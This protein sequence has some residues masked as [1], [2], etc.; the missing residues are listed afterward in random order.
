MDQP[1]APQSGAVANCG[2]TKGD[3]VGGGVQLPTCNPEDDDGV[4]PFLLPA[5]ALPA[6]RFDITVL[7]A[8]SA[9][10]DAAEFDAASRAALLMAPIFDLLN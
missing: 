1:E 8:A 6:A 9:V 4:L 7:A 2:R 10:T 3:E 5:G